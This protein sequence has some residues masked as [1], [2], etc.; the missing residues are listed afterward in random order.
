MSAEM[1]YDVFI[2]YNH[3][4]DKRF[5]RRLQRQLQ[6][7]GKAWWQKRA[8]RVFRDESS[9]A[10][11]P[12]LWP[13]I[14]RALLASRYLVLCASPEAAASH[15]VGKE[16]SFWLEKKGRNT[17][18]IA[19]TGGELQWDEPLKD[20]VWD[21]DTPL[22]LACRSAF[23]SEPKWIDCRAYRSIG[24]NDSRDAFLNI[25]ADFSS[26][27]RGVPKEDLLSEEVRQQRRALRMAYAAALSLTVLAVLAGVFARNAAIARGDTE[28]TAKSAATSST[29]FIYKLFGGYEKPIITDPAVKVELLDDAS[30]LLDKI[31]AV[32]LAHDAASRLA[33]GAVQ[34]ERADAFLANRQ[35]DLATESGLDGVRQYKALLES[36]TDSANKSDLAVAYERLGRAQK[37]LGRL[38][39]ASTSFTSGLE[40]LNGADISTG[41]TT[42]LTTKAILLLRQGEAYEDLDRWAEALEF[43]KRSSALSAQ[44]A[45]APQ[46]TVEHRRLAIGGFRK[47]GAG[48]LH[49]DEPEKALSILLEV[50]SKSKA[51]LSELGSSPP[52]L[53]DLAETHALLAECHERLNKVRDA[54]DDNV[55]EFLVSKTLL[56]TTRSNSDLLTYMAAGN[57][58]ALSMIFR[59]KN[60]S[61]ATELSI[62][63]LAQL[64]SRQFDHDPE[65]E[66]ERTTLSIASAVA[67]SENTPQ[68]GSIHELRD[69][70]HKLDVF[71]PS[72]TVREKWLE[73]RSRLALYYVRRLLAL[74]E[75]EEAFQVALENVSFSKSQSRGKRSDLRR[76]AF[77]EGQ[78]AWNAL[79]TNRFSLALEKANSASGLVADNS[80]S[81]LDF[82]KLNLAHALLFNNRTQEA[83]TEYRDLPRAD[84]SSDF[85]VMMKAG[86]FH[87]VMRRYLTSK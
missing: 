78:L 16:V 1:S 77:A 14:E 15:W 18:L 74:H 62:K 64:S 60:F 82:I 49:K 87:P 9:L 37:A 55:N 70:L 53:R 84:V 27:I 63:L 72:P 68:I 83:L 3:R 58:V 38:E 57:K 71:V 85:S 59:E 48:Y 54:A 32:G 17:L 25:A 34:V 24:E 52:M 42:A 51:L 56:E 22:P 29:R 26:V 41:D 30:E 69:I 2:S 50:M 65:L 39:E 79:L 23:A 13:A 43:Y 21:K 45:S 5:V 76:I 86:I 81:G 33:R 28:K 80:F 8:I 47:L 10:A 66:F 19:L 7:L 73:L 46:S 12:E 40:L 61:G 67:S 4:L 11:A 44:I 36:A 75:V 35:Y 31:S 6:S 20:F